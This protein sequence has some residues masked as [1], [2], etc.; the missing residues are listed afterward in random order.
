MNNNN[1]NV[2]KASSTLLV[3]SVSQKVRKRG[4][5]ARVRSGR[6]GRPR[7]DG[8]HA[9]SLSLANNNPHPLPPICAKIP[10][11]K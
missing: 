10:K 4:K 11:K 7:V 8:S 2:R 5:V 1:N 3:I 6:S 9:K